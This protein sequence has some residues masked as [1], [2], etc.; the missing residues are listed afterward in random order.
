MRHAVYY[1]PAFGTLLHQL[2]TSWLGRDAVRDEE[3]RQ[4]AVEGIS[5][6]TAEPARYGLHATLTAP[7]NLN[8]GARRVELGDAVA[9]LAAQM[10]GVFIP[11]LEL[12]NMD[13]FL[14]LVPEP[15]VSELAELAEMCVR[16]IDAYR[17]PPDDAELARRSSAGLSAN[18]KRFL[19]R[20]GYPYVFDEFRFHITLTRKLGDK[21]Q[22]KFMAAANEHFAPVIGQALEVD[23][24]TVFA[25]ARVSKKFVVEE[26][27]PLRRVGKMRVA[28]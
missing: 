1:S 15:P 5:G 10:D 20:W 4:P 13:G 26:R 11:K 7:F 8:A 12:R 6:V 2:G 21:E 17:A 27:F 14:A 24:L 28:S 25:E 3:V 16:A 23:A 18:Q 19:L 22:N 9:L